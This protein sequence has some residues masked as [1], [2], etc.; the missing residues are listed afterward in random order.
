MEAKTK[1]IWVFIETN[2]D[3]TPK[4]VGLELLT[5]G[6]M[7]A[8]KQG[9]KLVAVVLGCNCSAAVEAASKHGADQVVVADNEIF[10]NYTTDAYQIALVQ[11]LEKY[12]PTSMMIGAT[13]NGR[14]LG[15]RVSSKLNTGLTADCTALDVDAET[16]NVLW[17]RPAFGGNLMATIICPD[18]RPQI[19]TVRPGVFKKSEQGEAKAEVIEEKIEVAPSDIRTRVV[20]LIK[21]MD[22]EKIDLEGAE[23]IVSGGRGIGGPEGFETHLKPLAEVL[24][25]T[26]GCSRAVV[27]AGWM[28]HAHQVGQTGK[29]VGPKLYIAVGISGAIQHVAGMSGSD[30]IVAVNKDEDASIFSIADYGVVGDYM[31]VIPVLTEEIKKARA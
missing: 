18:H 19:G 6:R 17:T 11:L 7:I 26:I 21:D 14:D 16:G 5:P 20:E 23:I 4:N 25:A 8:E 29:T 1:D 27:D 12:A 24:N 3:G 31:Q 13:N 9:G 30:I 28:S 10:K 2:E 15:P 22:S